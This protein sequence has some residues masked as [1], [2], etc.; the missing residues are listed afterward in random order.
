[1]KKLIAV[2][3]LVLLFVLTGCE[4]EKS[5]PTTRAQM[6]DNTTS[7]TNNIESTVYRSSGDMKKYK[8]YIKGSYIGETENLF[9][10]EGD[11]SLPFFEVL[12]EC[13]ASFSQ[14]SKNT[15]LMK[16][17]DE[18]YVLN[19]ENVTLI[20]KS[21]EFDYLIVPPGGTVAP[22]KTE[23]ELYISSSHLQSFF[24]LSKIQLCVRVNPYDCSVNIK[25]KS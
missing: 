15:Y 12:E 11:V 20:K 10:G 2:I 5:Q 14:E 21:D 16:F 18:L 22:I 6:P 24:T 9:F 7:F 17:N 8:L 23:S 1:M 25:I 13:G 4:T 3:F 19:T